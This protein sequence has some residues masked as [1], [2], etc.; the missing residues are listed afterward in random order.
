MRRIIVI[1]LIGCL[2]GCSNKNGLPS[3]VLNKDTMQAVLWDVIQS[4]SFTVQFIKKD[5]LKNPS[6]ENAK[7]QQQIF[8]IHK[9]SYNY[10]TGHSELMRALLDSM[11]SKGEREKYKTLLFDKPS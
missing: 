5:T 10:Y 11:T 4:E 6:A 8:A 3:G 9:I 1:I 2:A 7:L